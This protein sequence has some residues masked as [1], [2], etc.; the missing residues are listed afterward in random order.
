MA[1][2]NTLREIISQI[3]LVHKKT[4]KSPLDLTTDFTNGLKELQKE[5]PQAAA[6]VKK[7][8]EQWIARETVRQ[9][10]TKAIKKK[11]A[12]QTKAKKPRRRI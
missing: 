2:E 7:Y 3:I 10:K 12:T 8:Y 4:G 9:L 1:K 11:K 5:N 6:R